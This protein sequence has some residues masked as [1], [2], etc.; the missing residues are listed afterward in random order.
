[1]SGYTLT[2]VTDLTLD[3]KCPKCKYTAIVEVTRIGDSYRQFSCLTCGKRWLI[4]VDTDGNARAE[5]V[6]P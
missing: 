5:A 6:R 2:P 1:M 3:S 4:V